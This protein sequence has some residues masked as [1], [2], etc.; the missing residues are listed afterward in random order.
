MAKLHE[1]C[2]WLLTVFTIQRRRFSSNEE[3]NAKLEPILKLKVNH[4]TKKSTTSKWFFY[5][6]RKILPVTLLFVNNISQ[7]WKFL[8]HELSIWVFI[9]SLNEHNWFL[10]AN[11]I[12]Y[13]SISLQIRKCNFIY[14]YKSIVFVNCKSNLVKT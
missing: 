9:T 14:L 3:V 11:E 6:W 13:S 12:T 8:Y 5:E 2:F 4:S 1:L 7:F 10:K